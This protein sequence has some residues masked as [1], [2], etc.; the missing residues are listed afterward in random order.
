MTPLSL[1]AEQV[2]VSERTLRRAVNQGTLRASRRSPRAL[3]IPV[4]ERAYAK[5]AWPLLSALKGA[6]RTEQGV[7]LA[8][9][10]G[11]TATGHDTNASDVDLLVELRDESLERIAD[12]AAKLTAAVGRPVQ[13]VRRHDAEAE[14]LFLADVVA[15][16]RVL[17]DR[18][19]LWP[20]LRERESAMRRHGRDLQTRRVHSALAGID[21]LL[22]A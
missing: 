3:E 18:E 2:G 12:L 15:Y 1:L 5:R 7:R 20:E 9:L 14:S 13:L 17:V 4:S 21:R 16:G 8:V 10:F 11:S 19:R 22:A 6:L